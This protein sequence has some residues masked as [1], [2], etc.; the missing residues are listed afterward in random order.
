MSYLRSVI[1]LPLLVV[2]S[3]TSNT[4]LAAGQSP[5]DAYLKGYAEIKKAGAA[6]ITAH[7]A[8]IKAMADANLTNAKALQTIEQT[9]TVALDNN[10]KAATTFYEKRKLNEAY[11]AMNAEDRPT[12]EDLAR[13]AKAT[14][15]DRPTNYQLEPVRGTIQWPEV[16]QREQFL[17]GR[18]Q[19]DFLFAHRST[20][21]GPSSE[22]CQQAQK[23][24]TA[25]RDELRAILRE[26][27]PAEYLAAR[28]FLDSLAYEAQFPP[29]VEG[30]AFN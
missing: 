14:L 29:R 15:P 13:Y 4:A 8:V 24:V 7:A 3:S 16:F 20:T 2:L 25:M 5:L 30:M 23:A 17:A 27:S 12:R 10:L 9:R 19:L 28:K 22:A 11:R 6:W 1:W 21:N 26:M 18:V